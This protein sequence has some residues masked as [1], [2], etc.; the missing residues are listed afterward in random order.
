MAAGGV[1]AEETI[2]PERAAGVL[3][4]EGLRRI[5]AGRVVVDNVSL[6]VAAGETVG[7]LGPNGA[8]KTT[9]FRMLAGVERADA[10]TVHLGEVRVDALPLHARARAGLGYLPQEDT[11]FRDLSVAENVALALSV[12]GKHQKVGDLL[13]RVGIAPLSGRALGGLSGGERRRLQIARLLAIEPR[14][15]LLDEPFAGIDPI[16][17]AGLQELIR[18]LARGGVG[19]LVTD[20]AVRETLGACDRALLL[21]QG[22]VQ[23]EGTPRAVAENEHARARY[24]GPDFTLGPS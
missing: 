6:S 17:I 24:L 13:E 23:V 22:V 9:V 8:G 20:H 18:G 7:L 4:A 1:R 14:V 21:D 5:Y 10:G 3:R 19:V 15:M 12:S 2:A 16:A 11:L